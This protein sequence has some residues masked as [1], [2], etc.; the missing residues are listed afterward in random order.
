MIGATAL[1][2]VEFHI[3]DEQGWLLFILGLLTV[4]A[5]SCKKLHINDDK[6]NNLLYAALTT[7]V[8][9]IMFGLSYHVGSTSAAVF[10]FGACLY[11]FQMMLFMW[12]YDEMFHERQ[13]LFGQLPATMTHVWLAAY[14]F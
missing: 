1:P 9:Y 4:L 12:R 5:V 7:F 11:P 2:Y 3:A 6:V 8:A 14:L 10:W 13:H